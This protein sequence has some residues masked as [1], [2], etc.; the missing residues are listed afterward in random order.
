M[1]LYYMWKK[2]SM[3]RV[4]PRGIFIQHMR[5]LFFMLDVSTYKENQ[6]H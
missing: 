6:K 3:G 4:C 5:F 1:Y 2:N